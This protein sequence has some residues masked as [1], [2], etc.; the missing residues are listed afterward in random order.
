MAGFEA[1]R[2]G[3]PIESIEDFMAGR[4]R[5]V[6]RLGQDA[7]AIGHAVW[8]AATR[9]GQNVVAA[10]PQEV[11][12]SGAQ[13]LKQQA[14]PP[15]TRSPVGPMPPKGVAKPVRRDVPV[16]SYGAIHAYQAPADEMAELCRQQAEFAKNQRVIDRENNWMAIPALAPAAAVLA[17]EGGAALAARLAGPQI[18]RAPLQF[19]KKDP[20]LRVGDNWA[21]R[22]GRR[23]HQALRERLEQKPGWDYEPNMTGSGGRTLKPDVGAPVRNRNPLNPE[24]RYQMELKPNTRSGRRAGA[25]QAK[26]YQD[27]TGNKTRP[28]YYNPGDFI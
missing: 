5:D 11:R 4:W 26:R 16:A 27:E 1:R 12:A 15:P 21:T 25:R 17:L 7:E 8:G 22:A 14:A 10:T 23:A 2:G 13:F 6:G 18:E 19:V 20:H 28:I 3:A 24:S 9:A